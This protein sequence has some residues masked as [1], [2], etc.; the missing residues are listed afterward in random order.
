M[1]LTTVANRKDYSGDG[2]VDQFAFPYLFFLE[3]DLTVWLYDTVL[4][5]L[6]L[7]T[8]TTHY[9]VTGEGDVDLTGEVTFVT[10]PTSDEEVI[11]LRELVFDQQSDYEDF[12][13]LPSGT[14]ETNLDRLTMMVQQLEEVVGRAIVQDV[15]STVT[16][17]FPA[18]DPLKVLQWN[19]GGTALENSTIDLSGVSTAEA[20]AVA[21]AANASTSETNA[22]VSE[23][24]AAASAV[25]AA[26]SASAA[27]ASASTWDSGG[28]DLVYWGNTEL[29]ANTL[30]VEAGAT[31]VSLTGGYRMTVAGSTVVDITTTGLNGLHTGSQ[32]NSTWYALLMIADSNGVEATGYLLVEAANYP[33]SITLPTDYDVYKRVGWVR[34]GGGG[35]FLSGQQANGVF[36][37]DVDQVILS[38]GTSTS[39]ASLS[40]TASAPPTTRQSVL[41]IYSG[42]SNVVRYRPTGSVTVNGIIVTNSSFAGDGATTAYITDSSQSVDY[43]VDSGSAS[44]LC[45]GYVDNLSEDS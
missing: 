36:L 4:A 14:L 2:I 43:K 21:A 11:I 7:Q 3:T 16:V 19:A 37:Y 17:T 38:S 41:R 15:N 25:A 20:N 1:S 24:N 44:I 10:P 45:W 26:G 13:R 5:T 33:S 28:R 8:L 29:E 40:M 35:G 32:A 31:A 6:S 30:T 39:W 12:N 42:A 18:P 9:T 22:G 23:T 34:N 27:A